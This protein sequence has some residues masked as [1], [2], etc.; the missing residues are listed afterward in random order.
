MFSS[1][2]HA[3]R[4]DY[5]HTSVQYSKF[6]TRRHELVLTSNASTEF[7]GRCQYS[8]VAGLAAA[9]RLD[10]LL[11]HATGAAA[12]ACGMVVD[13]GVFRQYTNAPYEGRRLS[14][15]EGQV[16]VCPSLM[17]NAPWPWEN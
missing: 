5:Y 9:I 8:I 16:L 11:L 14:N 17:S 1:R 13:R 15:T 12:D 2:V 10:P 4:T 6:N 3:I 7:M